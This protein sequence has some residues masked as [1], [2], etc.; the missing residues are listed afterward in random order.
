MRGVQR[1][2]GRAARRS[3]LAGLR[4][5]SSG[6]A[7][8]AGATAR[9]TPT[10]TRH[11]THLCGGRADSVHTATP[12]KTRQNS[13]VCVV[14][15]TCFACRRH[16]YQLA[17]QSNGVLRTLPPAGTACTMDSSSLGA[18]RRLE[19]DAIRR[20]RGVSRRA[21]TLAAMTSTCFRANMA[22]FVDW[23]CTTYCDAPRGGP[24]HG[25]RSHAHKPVKIGLVFAEICS[26]T[27]RQ[28]H[29]EIRL[30]LRSLTQY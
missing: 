14:S 12:G 16:V 25:C 5:S 23:K 11:R 18:R 10:Q 19:H 9:R 20:S 13:P 26:R 4:R 1:V 6:R 24:S 3:C 2:G 22:S 8:T 30:R 17:E 15:G 7:G 21:T 28:T 27:D 29:T